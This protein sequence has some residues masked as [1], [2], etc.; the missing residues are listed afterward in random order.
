LIPYKTELLHPSTLRITMQHKADWEQWFLLTS[1]RHWDN[2]NSDWVMQKRHLDEAIERNAGIIDNGDFFCAMQG[3]FDKRSDK[4]EIRS[5]H[6]PQKGETYLD[7]LVKTAADFFEPYAKNFILMGQ[8]NHESSIKRN[9][10]TDLNQRLVATLNDRTGSTIQYGGYASWIWF[11]SRNGQSDTRSIKMY[12]TH[13]FGGS[14][15][16]TRGIIQTNRRQAS[17]TG[18]DIIM[19]GHIHESWIIDLPS[20]SIDNAGVPYLRETTHLCLPTYKEEHLD[21]NGWHTEKGHNPKP[22]GAYWL[23][24][25]YRNHTLHR[26]L[27][28]V[29]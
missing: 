9:H 2:P 4:A 16:V 13:G 3:K 8:G 21:H 19:S 26:E 29:K 24:L 1:D 11:M 7:L 14:A 25:Y 12:R 22:L 17:I 6:L 28:R 15:P 5:M 18:A 23:R 20:E 27:T 10:E